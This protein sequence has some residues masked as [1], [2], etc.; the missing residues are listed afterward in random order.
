MGSTFDLFDGHCDGQSGL[1]IHFAH[2]RNICYSDCD[3]VTWCERDLNLCRCET[4]D[5][6][7]LFTWNL[8]VL[9][10]QNFSTGKE[11]FYSFFGFLKF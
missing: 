10:L 5:S 2:L 8:G 9:I 11:N 7:G 4:R 3:G 6:I 1:H